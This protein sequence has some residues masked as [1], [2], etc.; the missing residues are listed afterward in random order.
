ML[1]AYS[2]SYSSIC[3][4]IALIIIFIKSQILSH[5]I[6]SW[7]HIIISFEIVDTFQSIDMNFSHVVSTIK[8][9]L[10]FIY[11]LHSIKSLYLSILLV[12]IKYIHIYI[13]S[14]YI[15]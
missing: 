2:Q 8:S 3:S 4:K 14:Q 5:S 1:I 10:W 11:L 7:R 13:L 15:I 12:F 9:K 6:I